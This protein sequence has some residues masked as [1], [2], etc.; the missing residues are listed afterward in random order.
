MVRVMELNYFGLETR[1]DL[2]I[3]GQK[4]IAQYNIGKPIVCTGL[5]FRRSLFWFGEPVTPAKA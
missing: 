1:G 4:L 2:A 5:P 3:S